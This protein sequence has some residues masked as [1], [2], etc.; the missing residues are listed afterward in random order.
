MNPGKS[1]EGD[2]SRNEDYYAFGE[3]IIAP[4][5]G[6]VIGVVDGIKDNTPGVMNPMYAPGNS[7]IIRTKNNEYLVFAH[8]KKHSAAVK[9]GQQLREG[10]LIALCGNSGNSSE[11]HLHFHIQNAED[12]N[13]A[14][15]VKCYFD[16]IYVNGELRKDYSPIK[17]D[18]VKNA[19]E[20][21][22]K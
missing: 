17:N 4:C 11:P 16:R 21:P 6:E 20:L 14:T 22:G 3:E 8:L 1:Y 19:G 12:M 5:D 2:G 13:N 15:G 7:V 10:T 18:K 9:E